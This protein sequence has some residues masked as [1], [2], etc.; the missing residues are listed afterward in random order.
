MK[1]KGEI[2]KKATNFFFLDG[3]INEF[4]DE[5]SFEE[6]SPPC[7]DRCD[8]KLR[9]Y[10]RKLSSKKRSN[11]S[12]FACLIMQIICSLLKLA[13][14]KKLHQS[15]IYLFQMIFV[16]KILHFHEKVM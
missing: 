12:R 9:E 13:R 5:E 2:C 11:Q 15:I 14:L 4:I 3:K 6:N 16:G 10:C 1:E 8:E 7:S